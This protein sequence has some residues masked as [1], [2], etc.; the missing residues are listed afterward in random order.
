M[1]KFL[2]IV[3]LMLFVFSFCKGNAISVA[4]AE[5]PG[6]AESAAEAASV[7]EETAADEL[8]NLLSEFVSRGKRLIQAQTEHISQAVRI[9]RYARVVQLILQ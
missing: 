4:A 2:S 9:L 5:I 1:K 3:C 7:E 8:W 6:S